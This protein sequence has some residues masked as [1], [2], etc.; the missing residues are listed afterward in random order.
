[1]DIASRAAVGA[2]LV[3]SLVE[4]SAPVHS[5]E[6]LPPA[7]LQLADDRPADYATR[8]DQYCPPLVNRPL[9]ELTVDIR[10]VDPHGEFVSDDNL[11]SNC[12]PAPTTE[13]MTWFLDYGHGC[14]DSSCR[15]LLQLAR[16]CHPKLLF[17]DPLLERY[18]ADFFCP[19]CHAVGEF[20]CDLVLLPARLLVYK[21]QPCV[22][23]PTPHCFSGC[24]VCGY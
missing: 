10:P 23:T 4:F 11:P 24:N 12:M 3:F 22:R 1:M 15:D 8:R 17:E 18:G 7:E 16:F 20:A 5:Q 14:R 2:L 13:H 19:S 21:R 9:N 6:P